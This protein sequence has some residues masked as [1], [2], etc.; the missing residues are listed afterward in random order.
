MLIRAMGPWGESLVGTYVRRRFQEGMGT[1]EEESSCLQSYFYHISATSPSG[2]HALRHIFEPFAWGKDPLER[3]LGDLKVPISF[4]YGEGDWM[5]PRSAQNVCH[6]IEKR[7]G[8]KKCPADRSISLIPGAGHF[9]FLDQ[10]VSS[11]CIWVS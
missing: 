5:D 6:E 10:P 9:V 7:S 8:P 11:F 1:T 4:I 2:E 3:R